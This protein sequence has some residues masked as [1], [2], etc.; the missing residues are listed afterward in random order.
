M[1]ASGDYG[2]VSSLLARSREPRE[3][4]G[5]SQRRMAAHVGVAP[6]VLAAWED[7][8]IIPPG[9]T[10]P[11]AARPWIAVLRLLD[12]TAPREGG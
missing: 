6:S 8:L 2:P 7:G 3:Q 5:V 9:L 10:R 4:A 1:H 12:A 11:E